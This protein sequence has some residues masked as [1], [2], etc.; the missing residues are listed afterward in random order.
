MINQERAALFNGFHDS[1]DIEMVDM[2]GKNHTKI[3]IDDTID[4]GFSGNCGEVIDTKKR[5]K[6]KKS[7]PVISS[8]TQEGE[9]KGLTRAQRRKK[10]KEFRKEM[11]LVSVDLSNLK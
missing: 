2:T 4:F 7:L 3:D 11:D 5:K 9:K 10:L 6:K 1:G 8:E